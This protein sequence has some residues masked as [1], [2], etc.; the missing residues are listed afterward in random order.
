MTVSVETTVRG[1]MPRCVTRI[2][3]VRPAAADFN[4]GDQRRM[5]LAEQAVG[6]HAAAGVADQGP[7][8]P[9]DGHVPAHVIENGI[10]EGHVVDALLHGD[11][12]AAAR[13]PRAADP[14]RVGQGDAAPAEAVEPESLGDLLGTADVLVQHDDQ[15]GIL[16]RRQAQGGQQEVAAFP[17]AD[18][19]PHDPRVAGRH[20]GPGQRCEVAGRPLAG[21]HERPTRRLYLRRPLRA[22]H[23]GL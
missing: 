22:L 16:L 13:V 15:R 14:G 20:A 9:V 10:D 18:R 1:D 21:E 3:L 19:Q 8:V 5:G 7:A 17:P 6:E 11:A 4:G 23:S 2:G 12:A